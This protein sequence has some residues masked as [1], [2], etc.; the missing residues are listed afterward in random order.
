M[1]S[2]FFTFTLI[3]VGW[4]VQIYASAPF[5]KN[6]LD[7]TGI[8]S[9]YQESLKSSISRSDLKLRSLVHLSLLIQLRLSLESSVPKSV[10]IALIC[11][12]RLCVYWYS[13]FSHCTYYPN[14]SDYLLISP[15]LDNP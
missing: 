8:N 7:A 2:F 12:Y 15:S 10:N 4:K 6:L 1:L 13:F 5:L 9:K 11:N 14:L 3:K